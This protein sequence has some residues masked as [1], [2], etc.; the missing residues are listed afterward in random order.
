MYLIAGLGNPGPRF[1]NNR[2]NVGFMLLD[3]M[4]SRHKLQFDRV[5]G[6]AQLG[7]LGFSPQPVLLAKPLS[8]MNRSGF[9]IQEL[10]RRYQID[11]KK[12]L[13]VYDEIA[14]PLGK[15]RIRVSGSSGGQKGMRSIIETLQTRE[16]PRLRIGV[17]RGGVPSDYTSYVLADFSRSEFRILDDVLE[18]A[19]QAVETVLSEGLDKAMAKFN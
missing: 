11:L 13:I 14:L 12:L 17:R 1:E 6:Q 9:V 18:R 16:I 8:F 2:H 4:A 5:I 15:I 3:R 19:E 10:V 7:L